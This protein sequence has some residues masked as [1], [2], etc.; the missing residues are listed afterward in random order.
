MKLEY[1]FLLLLSIG[2]ETTK[3]VFSNSFSKEILKNNTD[4]YKFN[5]FMYLGSVAVLSFFGIKPMSLFTVLLAF[6]FAVAIWFNQVFFLKALQYGSLSFSNFIQ[7]SGLII[8]LI[9]GI[10]VWQEKISALQVILIL[11]LIAAMGVAL[12]IKKGKT[13]NKWLIFSF[14]AMLFLGI[15]GILQTTHQ[16][17]AHQ[18][19]LFQFLLISF[20]F[21]VILNALSWIFTEKKEPSGYKII[22][23]ALPMA[24]SCGVFMGGVHI[25][26]LFLAGVCP[27]VIFFPVVNGGLIFVTLLAA[28]IFF[29]E[30]LRLK[31]W[32]AIIIGIIALSLLGI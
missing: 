5:T 14:L 21:T 17:S 18:D 28:V 25:L 6:L 7:G 30:K 22:S 1:Y 16:A 13:N 2:L 8:P 32:I 19:E 23:R 15:I 4:I 29:K 26:N 24:I 31:Q 27:K 20:V 3:N 11:V 12:D 9:Y 10:F